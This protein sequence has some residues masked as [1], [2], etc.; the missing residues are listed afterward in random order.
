MS[1]SHHFIL[2]PTI[3]NKK[4]EL[5]VNPDLLSYKKYVFRNA[6]IVGIRYGVKAI[7]G[8]RFN[9]GRI[10]CIDVKSASG[11]VIKIRLKSLYGVRKKTLGEKYL[12]ITNAIFKSYF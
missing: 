4:L 5:I 7:A 12:Q 1:E 3:L 9:I 8:Y 11:K 10:Y 2:K 6:E